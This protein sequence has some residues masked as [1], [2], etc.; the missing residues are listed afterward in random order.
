MALETTF[1]DPPSTQ[2]NPRRWRH[3]LWAT[4]KP[5]AFLH[6]NC[7]LPLVL[8]EIGDQHPQWKPM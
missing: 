4:A 2:K 3:R 1:D 8:P 7:A 5:S 6:W